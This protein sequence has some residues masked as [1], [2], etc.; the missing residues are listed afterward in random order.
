LQEEH[1]VIRKSK[2]DGELLNWEDYKQMEFTQNVGNY[3][4]I[5]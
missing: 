3:E 2:M 1:Q 4:P 5:K